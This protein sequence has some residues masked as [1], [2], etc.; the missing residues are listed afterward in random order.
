MDA[1]AFDT[2]VV[3]LGFD[4]A[5]EVDDSESSRHWYQMD[6]YRP[7][8]E[9]GGVWL[10]ADFD[11]LDTAINAYLHDPGLHADRRRLLREQQLE[12]M[13]GRASAR[14]V[15]IIKELAT[16]KHLSPVDRSARS[17]VGV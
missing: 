9:S 10:A 2:C 1:V 5:V 4:G 13:D 7:V 12:P 6:H 15:N 16:Q 14:I 8:L 3:N 11:E 17:P